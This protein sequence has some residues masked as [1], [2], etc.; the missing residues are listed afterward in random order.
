MGYTTVFK[1]QLKDA[2]DQSSDY[3]VRGVTDRWRD[4]VIPLKDL[5]GTANLVRL[6]EF[7]RGFRRFD[8]N[9]QKGR[10]LP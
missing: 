3:Y 5:Q 6:K 1:V 4:I 7:R 8:R 9:S 10:D 2:M